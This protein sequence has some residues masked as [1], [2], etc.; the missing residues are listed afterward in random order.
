MSCR[1]SQLYYL[2]LEINLKEP[3]L[4]C[5]GLAKFMIQLRY[6]ITYHTSKKLSIIF[7]TVGKLP[8]T[9]LISCS[10]FTNTFKHLALK[11]LHFICKSILKNNVMVMNQPASWAESAANAVTAPNKPPVAVNS[12]MREK[13]SFRILFLYVSKYDKNALS[14]KMF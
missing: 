11:W 5:H 9:Y 3:K 13:T 7:I 4:S 12:W 14:C 1:K 8:T 10:L 6:L 2:Y